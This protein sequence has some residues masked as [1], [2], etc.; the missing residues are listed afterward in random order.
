MKLLDLTIPTPA[1]NLACDEALLD[2]CESGQCGELL[3]FWESTERFVV[4]GY[5]NRADSEVDTAACRR[6]DIAILRRCSGG[7]TVVQGPGCLNYALFLRID[8][9]LESITETNRFVMERNRTA[10]QDVVKGKIE[11]GGVTDLVREGRKFSGNAQRRRRNFLLFH[12]SFLLDCDLSLVEEVL[13][14]PT[15]Q[16]DYRAGRSHREF[17]TSLGLPAA[18][19]KLALRKEWNAYEPLESIPNEQIERLTRERYLTGEWNKPE[20]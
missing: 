13:K 20:E 14:F 19:V 2:W 11:V 8:G 9:P 12:G 17:L 5:G 3:R 6:R 4:L 15:R 7:G 10:L 16:P 1:G 18:A